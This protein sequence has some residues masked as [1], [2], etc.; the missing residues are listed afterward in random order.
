MK[1]KIYKI[2]AFCLYL[3]KHSRYKW[4]YK[5][6]SLFRIIFNKITAFC[7]YVLK[8][9]RHKWNYKYL[10]IVVSNYIQ[11]G[12]EITALNITATGMFTSLSL[13]VSH[14]FMSQEKLPMF[15]LFHCIKNILKVLGDL[16]NF[17][18]A[19]HSVALIL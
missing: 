16:S 19:K 9:S 8:Y 2:T 11:W 15:D 7:V 10:F 14:L 3:L 13:I 12:K 6:L 18:I 1:I 4:N 17:S 5:Y